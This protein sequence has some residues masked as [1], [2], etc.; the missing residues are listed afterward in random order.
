MNVTATPAPNS[1]VLL[2]IEVPA[3]RVDKAVGE[4]VRRLARQTKV[5]GF[6]PGKAP[7]GV[8]EAVLGPGAV[9]DEAVEI[10]VRDAYREA[11]VEADVV[12]LTE[13]DVEVVEA[14]EGKPLRFKATVQVRP[15]V[16]LGDYRNFPFRPSID[17]PDDEKVDKVIEELREQQAVLAPVEDRGA[18]TGDYAIIGYRGSVDGEPFEGGTAERM[19]LIL[20]EER[21]IPGFEEQ[22]L[23]LGVGD[24]KTF[25][26]TFPEDY[27]EASLAGKDATF[28]VQMKELRQRILPDADDDLAQSL[29]DF[30][31]M[32]ALRAEVRGRLEAN[33][34]D[35]ARH[36]F[37]DRIIEYAVA[38]ADLDLPAVLVDQEVEVM[39][40][41][42]RM[43]LARQGID[44]AAYL[45]ATER[46]E[47][48]LHREFREP[49][50]K[51]VKT[52]LVL[53]KI[54]DV[55]GL[56]VPDAAVEAEVEQ[57]RL[58]YA[59][60][61]KLVGYFDSERGRSFIRSSLRRT[62][63]VE[64]LVDDWLAAHPEHPPLPHIEEAE[65]AAVG[66]ESVQAAAAIGAT[67]PAA[68][69]GEDGPAPGSAEGRPDREQA[70]GSTE[71]G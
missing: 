22:L 42:L 59:S 47:E 29:G 28:E 58:R 64:Q 66:Q 55:E 23:G 56:Q 40:D 4:A 35:R 67:D 5:P 50:E 38:N 49:A 53:S 52:L 51:R 65:Q 2:E 30:A 20:G 60:D 15:E 17:A 32:A 62:R 43:N 25:A 16:T 71:A 12:P 36:E 27:G 21:L 48:D 57:A 41:E 26:V 1:S 61:P 68:V 11:V 6:R 33:S 8:L 14:E 24:E 69:L 10:A 44:E 7:R 34:I 54:A 13:A 3:D 18:E 19:P 70:D 37:A 63:V 31:D 39:H 45:K 46:S 9:F